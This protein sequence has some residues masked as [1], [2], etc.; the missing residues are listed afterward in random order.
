MF[1]E[2]LIA[3]L[4]LNASEFETKLGGATKLM[5]AFD[6]VLGR[7]GLGLGAGA[8]IAFFDNVMDRAGQLQDLSEQ[9]GIT[10]DSIQSLDFTA[11]QAGVSTE[12]LHMVYGKLT[13]AG[14]EAADKT[15]SAAK[16]LA[17]L[18]ISAKAFN[19]ASVDVKLEMVAKASAAA[20]DK[21]AAFAAVSDLLGSKIAP[22]LTGVLKELAEKGLD[23]VTKSAK[24]AGQVMDK[25][26]IRRLDELGDKAVALKDRV[27]VLGSDMLGIALVFGDA[28]GEIFS[29]KTGE[30]LGTMIAGVTNAMDGIPTNF[31]KARAA[32]DKLEVAIQS[33][34]VAS[35]G[36]AATAEDLKKLDE[37]R[38]KLKEREL[39]DAGKMN[40]WLDRLVTLESAKAQWQRESKEWTELET[41]SLGLQTKV[42]EARAAQA[43]KAADE[44]KKAADERAS[45]LRDEAQYWRKVQES[46]YDQMTTAEKFNSLVA[47]E[48]ELKEEI[49]LL[50]EGSA[51][52]IE[53][54]TQL[55]DVQAKSRAVAKTLTAEIA[56]E[57]KNR[58]EPAQTITGTMS[59]Q[60]ELAK[61]QLIAEKDLT[62]EIVARIKK[63]K[64]ELDAKNKIVTFGKSY[65]DQSTESLS[66][67]KRN[68]ETQL[69]DA[70]R[71]ARGSFYVGGRDMDIEGNF[72][73]GMG[74][75]IQYQLAQVAKELEAR[76]KFETTLR[77]SG[78]D[79]ARR[80]Y[81][82]QEFERLS[83][84][85]TGGG[86][87]NERIAN[88]LASIEDRLK[89]VF[90][91]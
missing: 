3:E 77:L 70:Q 2:K 7:I 80:I 73:S 17:A 34:W 9:L 41:E 69:T 71:N 1:G 58:I 81:S 52:W 61:L 12:A 60:Q 84:A 27:K 75:T 5:G 20:E 67:V 74:A 56:A 83:A 13:V 40:A 57:E 43:K 37:A 30:K 26:T 18:G 76:Q 33:V 45:V 66:Y 42:A 32:A 19:E 31:E 44:G 49:A 39:D 21:Q 79:F 48:R 6:S 55:L 87:T 62:A 89:P 78:E 38:A 29:G 8:V 25:E 23:G 10:T 28:I 16:A 65:Y 24:E 59:K 14:A 46:Q 47:T 54:S 4:G 64:E 86:D 50:D 90:T 82:P 51:E 53:K 72:G 22:R 35:K 15:T 68:L 88:T 11:K 36:A 63:L 85:A 91:K